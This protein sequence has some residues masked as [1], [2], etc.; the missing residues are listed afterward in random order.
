MRLHRRDDRPLRPSDLP[1][2]LHPRAVGDILRGGEVW[3]EGAVW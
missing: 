1:E 2:A 3:D